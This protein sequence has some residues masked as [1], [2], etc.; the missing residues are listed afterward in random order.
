M[1][2]AEPTSAQNGPG[3][4]P[5]ATIPTSLIEGMIIAVVMKIPE[6]LF[7]ALQDISTPQQ[8]VASLNRIYLAMVLGAT[9]LGAASYWVFYLKYKWPGVG[10]FLI[11]W[12]A[13]ATYVPMVAFGWPS[14]ILGIG[15][16]LVW[17][18]YFEDQAGTPRMGRGVR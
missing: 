16:L 7:P 11:G 10:A 1:R 14:F 4:N 17:W 18:Y 8:T 3:S 13:I 15:P 9:I 6:A 2:P 12:T 5:D